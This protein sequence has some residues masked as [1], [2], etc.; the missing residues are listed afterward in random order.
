LRVGFLRLSSN[1][2]R[3]TPAFQAFS[4]TLGDASLYLCNSRYP[5][6][7]ENRHLLGAQATLKPS[8]LKIASIK[9]PENA[10]PDDVFRSS[11]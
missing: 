4:I 5:Y 2:V 11:R 10:E 6:N 7:F 9:L 1:V 3:P 8:Q